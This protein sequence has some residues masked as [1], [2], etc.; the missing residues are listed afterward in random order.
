MFAVGVC[1]ETG[2]DMTESE[3]RNDDRNGAVGVSVRR[4]RTAIVTLVATVLV[5]FLIFVL[6]FGSKLPVLIAEEALYSLFGV[7]VRVESVRPA[8]LCSVSI[9]DLTVTHRRFNLSSRT[10]VVTLAPSMTGVRVSRIEL[11]DP[12]ILIKTQEK[13]AERMGIQDFLNRLENVGVIITGG[14]VTLEGRDRSMTFSGVT[15]VHRRFFTV[16]FISA[17]AAAETAGDGR[18]LTLSGE[19]TARLWVRGA[20]GRRTLTGDMRGDGIGYGVGGYLFSGDDFAVPL[21]L[22]EKELAIDGFVIDGFGVRNDDLNMAFSDMSAKGDMRLFPLPEEPAR[23]GAAFSDVSVI[24]PGTGDVDLELLEVGGGS[25]EVIARTED[26]SV[27]PGLIRSLGD[28]LPGN[29]ES[30]EWGGR[31]SG[32]VRAGHDRNGTGGEGW[33]VASYRNLSF[34]SP[35][36]TYVADGIDG[37]LETSWRS[38]EPGAVESETMLTASGFQ[39]L[40]GDV[41]VDFTDRVVEADFSET[42]VEGSGVEDLEWSVVVPDIIQV[43]ATGDMFFDRH[44]AAGNLDLRINVTDMGALF[45]LAVRDYVTSRVPVLA[46]GSVDG[47]IDVRVHLSGALSA[48]RLSGDVALDIPD[49]GFGSDTIG[50]SDLSLVMPFSFSLSDA[51]PTGTAEDISPREYGMV[52]LSG[53]RFF[54]VEVGGAA[55]GAAFIDNVFTIDG[56]VIVPISHGVLSVDAFTVTNPFSPGREVTA[57]F[58]AM[59]IDLTPILAANWGME[60]GG[61]LSGGYDSL[62]IREG[63]LAT[64]G[65]M[66]VDIA[67]G[68]VA[69][70]NLWGAEVF[71]SRRR[72]GMDISFEDISL[73][74]ITEPTDIGRVSGVVSGSLKDLIIAYGGP[75]RFVFDVRTVDKRG[76]PKRVSVDFVDNISILGSGTDIFTEALNKGVNRFV[77]EYRYS[78]MGIH[79]ELEGAYFTVSGTVV[80]GGTEYFIKRSGPFGINVVNRN[81]HNSIRFKDMMSR[82]KRIQVESKE[83]IVIEK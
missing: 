54:G 83:D 75:Q 74:K 21:T 73:E 40:V 5:I 62:E 38:P 57:D 23:R 42:L 61:T 60:M 4:L 30:W 67:E 16:G 9:E 52:S 14:R 39:A 69:V 32:E 43:T 81:P 77:G 12:I 22:D 56:P 53:A 79:L 7:E 45:D 68:E 49:A 37:A 20:R 28:I 64:T 78:E 65:S 51:A 1:E 27:T 48:P 59:D 3:Y 80:D 17:A 6:R 8:G 47:D 33:V 72:I 71:S 15:A 66:N 36:W 58:E 18:G 82:L 26:A 44:P 55:V 35:E 29:T 31:V 63:K 11:N 46:E 50:V 70:T 19:V 2:S 34:T 76:V 10:A 25:W 24:V 13:N 41:Y